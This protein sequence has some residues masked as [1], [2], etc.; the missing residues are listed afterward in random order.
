VCEK[1]SEL[2]A[3]LGVLVV[4]VVCFVGWCI[5][6]ISPRSSGW[7]FFFLLSVVGPLLLPELKWLL[8]VTRS[9]VDVDVVLGLQVRWLT[10]LSIHASSTVLMKSLGN[11]IFQN[12]VFVE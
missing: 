12:L 3:K 2:E 6:S 4:N 8:Y 7:C 5:P 11:F 10:S 9:P 1:A